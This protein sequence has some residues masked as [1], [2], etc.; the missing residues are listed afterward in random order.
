MYSSS[1]YTNQL[2]AVPE[3]P[4]LLWPNPK[5]L[6][7]FAAVDQHGKTFELDDIENKWSFVFFGYTHCPDVC[8][9]TLAVL[10]QLHDL[11]KDFP[12]EQN[13][14]TIFMTV[15]PERD[16]KETLAEYIHYFN[17]SFIALGGNKTQI[18]SLT[19]QIGVAYFIAENED[20]E[21][22]LVEHSASIFLIDPYG[23]LVAIFS[24]PH[25]ASDISERFKTIQQFIKQNPA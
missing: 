15:D 2:K 22:Y 4:G 8:P 10:D 1:Y 18:E 3:I 19:R 12:T 6:R 9:V 7:P 13:I 20:S 17:G 11:L 5:Q 14:Q 21:N 23:R 25:Q 16:T 24:A